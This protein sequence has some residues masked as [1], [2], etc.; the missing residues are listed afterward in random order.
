MAAL[1]EFVAQ[2]VAEIDGERVHKS[3]ERLGGMRFE[4]QNY[5]SHA[6]L[7]EALQACKSC[8]MR[9]D[10]ADLAPWNRKPAAVTAN[11]QG[12]QKQFEAPG[13]DARGI[14][15]KQ[16]REQNTKCEGEPRGIA[17]RAVES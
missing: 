9:L 1:G 14:P 10:C 4:P 15:G 5:R 3:S 17:H 11:A 8:G 7:P 12:F 16:K 2:A 6:A 13:P